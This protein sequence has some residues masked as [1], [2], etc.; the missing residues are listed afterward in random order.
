M[1][2]EFLAEV[3]HFSHPD[4]PLI[5]SAVLQNQS[6]CAGCN[7]RVHGRA[8]KCNSSCDYVLHMTCSRLAEYIQHKFHNHPLV[9]IPRPS[10]GDDLFTC[11]AC[12]KLIQGFSYRCELCDDFN[13]HSLCYF[14]PHKVQHDKHPKHPLTLSSSV[15]Y[16]DNRFS[17][18]V[19]NQ[20]YSTSDQWVYR[21]ESCKFDV[22]LDCLGSANMVTADGLSAVENNRK[23]D[24]Y[25]GIGLANSTA[26]IGKAVWDAKHHPD[27]ATAV[28]AGDGG[29]AAADTGIIGNQ[30]LN[31]VY[32]HLSL[33]F[34]SDL[35]FFFF[36]RYNGWI[37]TIIC[38]I[39]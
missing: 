12:A 2:S 22:H 37:F 1:S 30:F 34:H 10:R 25:P 35:S 21:C 17:C 20:W 24:L 9:L 29:A 32:L 7:G 11:K 19:C 4:H 13:L 6:L 33:Y 36:F 31:Y 38:L 26:N 18:K 15:P 3:Q 5:L 23:L 16:R 27:D 39:T 14:M 28:A 8:Y